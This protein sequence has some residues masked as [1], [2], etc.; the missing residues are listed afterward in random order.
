MT[1]VTMTQK[2]LPRIH[3][4]LYHCRIRWSQKILLPSECSSLPCYNNIEPPR[5]RC[6]TFHINY[7]VLLCLPALT[8]FLTV[9]LALKCIINVCDFSYLQHNKL[10]YK[11]AQ[12]KSL[13]NNSRTIS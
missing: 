10:S 8:G 1:F 3:L 4:Y 6:V 7:Y 12:N 9:A 13:Q 5:L 2:V 11:S